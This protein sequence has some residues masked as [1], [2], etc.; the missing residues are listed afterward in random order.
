MA[1][2]VRASHVLV[3]R[4]TNFLF[5]AYSLRV[6]QSSMEYLAS[7][8]RGLPGVDAGVDDME[9]DEN[10]TRMAMIWMDVTH[11]NNKTRAVKRFKALAN[12][13][14]PIAIQ[15]LAIR[16]LRCP[17]CGTVSSHP[18]RMQFV[19]EFAPDNH[20]A[21][22]RGFEGAI[23][24]LQFRALLQ[25]DQEPPYV[26]TKQAIRAALGSIGASVSGFQVHLM[27][28]PAPCTHNV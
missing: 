21:F 8:L 10:H 23:R 6:P 15:Q 22:L 4:D 25:A 1:R 24:P 26:Q 2:A 11:A 16:L 3:A 18:D 28:D 17:I 20:E 5:A 13:E 12:P 14:W 9:V 7:I 19:S 27:F